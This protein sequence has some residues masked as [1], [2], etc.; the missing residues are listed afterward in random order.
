MK[1]LPVM[2]EVE[3]CFFQKIGM[4]ISVIELI[5]KISLKQP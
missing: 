1:N 5:Y 2:F 4:L 3:T